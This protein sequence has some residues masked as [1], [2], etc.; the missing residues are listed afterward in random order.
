M[1]ETLVNIRTNLYPTGP[2]PELG[3]VS[4][5]D[6]RL[7]STQ[8]TYQKRSGHWPAAAGKRRLSRQTCPS[9]PL[10]SQT[11]RSEA[12][13]TSS[14]G[15]GLNPWGQSRTSDHWTPGRSSHGRWQRDGQGSCRTC[16]P[17]M[18]SGTGS[19]RSEG[20]SSGEWWWRAHSSCRSLMAAAVTQA[21]EKMKRSAGLWRTEGDKIK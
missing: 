14:T 10:W 7:S 9:T 12:S 16:K 13:Q 20:P 4:L 19:G 8:S 2:E 5:D 6:T 15:P 21:E 11:H 18:D 3:Q 17:H 1:F